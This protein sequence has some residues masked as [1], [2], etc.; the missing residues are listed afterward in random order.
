MF[1]VDNVWE[2]KTRQELGFDL[3]EGKGPWGT[4]MQLLEL[5]WQAALVVEVSDV[6][7][8]EALNSTNPGR[9]L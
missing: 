2:R 3:S 8:L 7:Q 5:A 4:I 1:L 6:Q 9:S